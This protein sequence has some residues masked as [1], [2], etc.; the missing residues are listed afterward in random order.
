[1]RILGKLVH[2]SK[3]DDHNDAEY[4]HDA[5]CASCKMK[6][7]R[8]VDRYHCLEC[9][10]YD[11]CARC[12]EKRR[13]TGTHSSGH[14]VVHFKLPNEF[15][16]IHVNN[17][18]NE[19]T[20]NKLQHSNTLLHEKHDGIACDGYCQQK[21]IVGLR[22]KCDTCPNY[23]LCETC[24]IQKRVCTKMHQKDHPMILTS[25]KMMPKM[26]PDDIELGDVL[27]RG[28]FGKYS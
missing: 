8:H 2:N 15:L 10:S 18:D 23:D 16:G 13:E 11:L 6:P 17:V 1:M 21:D 5:T 14:A 26:D 28:A 25:N 7:I 3:S 22:F 19:V 20:L 12:F 9:S 24:G 4:V 27:G